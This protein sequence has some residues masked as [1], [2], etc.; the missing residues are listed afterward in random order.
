MSHLRARAALFVL[1][2]AIAGCGSELETHPL[3]GRVELH[4]G[5]VEQLANSQIELA[6]ETDPTVRASG[7]IDA[8]GNF[9]VQTLYQGRVVPGARAGTYRVRLLPDT[10]RPQRRGE[11]PFVRRQYLDFATSGLT[12]QVPNSD[13][14]TFRV[15]R[16]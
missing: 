16:R 9:E 10:D 8:D 12:V 13:A 4:D 7:V 14:V 15:S 11:P 6:L 2:I 5:A 3:R 1:G